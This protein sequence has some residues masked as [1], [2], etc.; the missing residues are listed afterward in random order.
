[1]GGVKQNKSARDAHE[2]EAERELVAPKRCIWHEM[3]DTAA[4]VAQQ[5]PLR[6]A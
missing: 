3:E 4:Y 2:V 1:M 6:E 5:R